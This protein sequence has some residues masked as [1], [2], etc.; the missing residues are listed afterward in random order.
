MTDVVVAQLED[1]PAWLLLA[2][3]VEPLFGPLVD[4][5]HFLGAL[6]RNIER[7]TAFC[8]REPGG[9]AEIALPGG[10][11]FSPNPPI[12]TIGWLAVAQR[13][14][15]QGIGQNLVEYVCGLGETP[16]ELVVT[17]FGAG[18]P[19]GEPARRFY[20]RLGFRAAEGMPNG[21]E[22]GSRQRFRCLLK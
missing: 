14:R 19:A 21:P 20:K 2:A 3:E 18:N 5:P 16:A 6:R 7:G 17:T 22:G 9:Y 11:P 4:D 13:C 10:L 1:I 8:V 15:R 12:Y